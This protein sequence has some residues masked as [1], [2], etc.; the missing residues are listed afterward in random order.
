MILSPDFKDFFASLNGARVRF[1]VVGGYAIVL[2]NHS[3]YT[4]AAG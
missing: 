3:Y 4:K 2:H 1:L